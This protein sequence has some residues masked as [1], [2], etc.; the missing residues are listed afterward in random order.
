[1]D[2]A[3]AANPPPGAEP[4]V[5]AP[6][7]ELGLI[8]TAE[9]LWADL[10]GMLHDRLQLA[11]LETQRAAESL[12]AILAYGIVVGVLAAGAWLSLAGAMV[13]W[14]IDQGMPASAALLLAALHNLIGVFGF[15]LAIRRKSRHLRFPAT[16]RSLGP[17]H[18]PAAAK[19]PRP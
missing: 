5:S 12:V 1:M 10:R 9:A 7:A 16:L 19:E 14:L 2:Q 11:A 4:P 15:A 8:A 13:L 18:A 17:D 6:G 3:R